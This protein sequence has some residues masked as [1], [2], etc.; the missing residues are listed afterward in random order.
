MTTM[1]YNIILLFIVLLGIRL[2]YDDNTSFKRDLKKHARYYLNALFVVLLVKIF[3]KYAS[4]TWWAGCS[5]S[6]SFIGELEKQDAHQIRGFSE[7]EDDDIGGLD[8]QKRQLDEFASILF[9]KEKR[10]ALKNMGGYAPRGIL[11]EGPPGT[12]KT[13]LARWLVSKYRTNF[14]SINASDLVTPYI[15]M[16]SARIRQLFASINQRDE[17]HILFI[18]EIDSIATSRTRAMNSSVATEEARILNSLL[19]AMDGFFKDNNNN[20]LILAATNR[21]DMLDEA[22]LRP[23]RFDRVVTFNLPTPEDREQIFKKLLP[24]SMNMSNTDTLVSQTAAF[25]GAQIQNVINEARMIAVK[26]NNNKDLNMENLQ[27]ALT[28]VM[29]GKKVGKTLKEKDKERLASHEA[30]HAVVHMVLNKKGVKEISIEPRSKGAG[31]YTIPDSDDPPLLMSSEDIIK[32]MLM[33]F[34]GICGESVKLNNV[35]YG[36]AHDLQQIDNLYLILDKITFGGVDVE[37]NNNELKITLN[38][39]E[40]EKKEDFYKKLYSVSKTIISNN[41]KSFETIIKNLL[42]H[43]TC[44]DVTL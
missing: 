5:Q 12:G 7:V 6:S 19:D 40:K 10:N 21:V 26:K 16:S 35:S 30:G 4:Y 3:V 32:K 43:N 36:F 34:G 9:D 39:Q 29:L 33:Y 11:M 17:K 28:V 8:D 2:S 20:V 22:I 27:E 42:E 15:G 24:K 38:D 1:V 41:Q 44:K 18:D 13:M 23:G 31:G 14:T 25:S 37:Y